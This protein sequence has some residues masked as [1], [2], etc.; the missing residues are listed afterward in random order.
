MITLSSTYFVQMTPGIARKW[1]DEYRYPKQRILR[2]WR[3]NQIADSMAAGD[4]IPGYPMQVCRLGNQLICTDGQHRQNAVIES[5]T[6]QA[7]TVI[8]L[9]CENELDV[10]RVYY[11]TDRNLT[12]NTAD[13][14]RTISLA[15][16]LGI[17]NKQVSKFGNAITAIYRNFS[18]IH[19]AQKLS[20][21]RRLDLMREF[22]EAAGVYFETIGGTPDFMR[23]P[24]YRASVI[25]VGIATVKYAPR[26]FGADKVRDFW[27]GLANGDGLRN[28]DPRKF[29]REHLLTTSIGHG[30]SGKPVTAEYQARYIASC[31]NAWCDDRMFASGRGGPRISE[32]APIVISGTPWNGK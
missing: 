5:G 27:S 19:D 1:V 29:A 21:E 2:K 23:D 15:N 9:C 11:K 18:N 10:E 22:G 3:V 8:E 26:Q 32:D 30:K 28:G 14:Y 4:W 12:R 13:V 20:D 17:S 6:T 7:F 25:G 31:F 16:E 24:L